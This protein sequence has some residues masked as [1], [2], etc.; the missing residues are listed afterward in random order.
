M[1]YGNEILI[2]NNLNMYCPS[3]L[4]GR[5]VKLLD[6]ISF[7]VNRNDMLGLVGETGAGKSILLDAIGCNP[8]LPLSV[9]ADQLLMRCDHRL[10]NLLQK[11]EE[12]LRKL[13][14]KR[15]AFVPPNALSNLNPILTVGKQVE[16]VIAANLQL[17]SK[18]ARQKVVEL[19]KMVQ[20]P[21]P[22]RNLDNYPHELSGGMAQRVVVSM[23]LAMSPELLLADEPTIG[24]DVTIQ[25]QVLDLMANILKKLQSSVV[26]ATRDLGIVANYCNKV[27]VLC[28]GQMVEFAEVRDFFKNA[29]HPYS[30]YLLAA[31]F[32]SHGKP[33][34]LESMVTK[35]EITEVRRQLGCRFA[36]RCPSAKEVCWSIYQP[37]QFITATHYVRCHRWRDN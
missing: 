12:G 5:N 21:D 16:N 29:V 36:Y 6:N 1:N 20:M 9:E 8:K 2:V 33:L 32:A 27:A 13:W 17:S 31:A 22:E 23:A 37:E 24:L 10:E 3:V 7:I 34:D 11:D 28:Y 14:G 26:L 19:F 4:E 18:E 35:G 25:T 30:R 15:I